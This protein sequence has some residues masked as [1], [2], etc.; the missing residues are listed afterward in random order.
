MKRMGILVATMISAFFMLGGIFIENTVLA[1]TP[2]ATSCI[3]TSSVYGPFKGKTVGGVRYV[4]KQRKATRF[5]GADIT[6]NH[7]VCYYRDADGGRIYTYRNA[8]TP[9]NGF[10]G[11]KCTK[12]SPGQCKAVCVW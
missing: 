3:K 5:E 11:S 2:H 12:S 7:L 4:T 8:C 6:S 1:A 9:A 10:S